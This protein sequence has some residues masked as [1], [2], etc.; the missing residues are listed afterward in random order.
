[1]LSAL[2]VVFRLVLRIFFRRIEVTGR[3]RVPPSGPVIF[4]LNHPNG[5]IDPAFLVCF[6]PRRVSFLAKAPLFRMPVV[7]WFCRRFQA[8]P[9]YRHQD[10]GVDASQNRETFEAARRVL[11]G[12]GAIAIFP[13]GTSHSD[14]RMRPLKTGAA[15][16]ALGAAAALGGEQS[17]AIV[18]AGI[19]YRAKQIFR[20]VAL[21]YFAEPFPVTPL[22]EPLAPGAEPP[23]GPVRELT[24]QI[25]RALAEVTLQAGRLEAL[26]LVAKAERI[27]RARDEPPDV[28]PT[29]AEEL[30]LRRRLV[31]GHDVL[32]ERW[33]D[34]FAAIEAR[35]VRYEATLEAAGVE[36][37][38]LTPR[39]YTIT[40]VTRYAV[41]AAIVFLI[42]L[43]LALA[44]AIVHYPAYRAVG[45]IATGIAKGEEETLA[46]VKLLA[47]ML[48]FPVTWTLAAAAA[49]VWL[50]PKAGLAVLVMLP[51]AGMGSLW[52]FERLDRLVGR[53]RALRLLLFRRRAFLRL[54][55]E[56]RAIRDQ[57]VELGATLEG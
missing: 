40:R 51:L 50:G 16:I 10:V 33:P 12:G 53:A 29:L 41:Q 38:H 34:R 14:P 42:L 55:A 1:V 56:R 30:E 24:A 49:W 44:G 46:S 54:T 18:P 31:L 21:L 28:V 47:A 57:I 19:Y 37:H 13:E 25:Q 20:S 11:G 43:P 9:V 35:I 45:H 27:L 22:A 48:L 7:G 2:R 6:A 4:V 8:I 32:R 39:G 23:A 17:I 3:D 15:R 52:F 26:A 36:P 5:L